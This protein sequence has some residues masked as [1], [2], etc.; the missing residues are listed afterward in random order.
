V[1]D[2]LM[3]TTSKAR[4]LETAVRGGDGASDL[5]FTPQEDDFRMRERRSQ[6]IQ[7]AT[8]QN[9]TFTEGNIVDEHLGQSDRRQHAGQHSSEQKHPGRVS[10]AVHGD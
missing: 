7:H 2:E 6:A 4:K 9:A 10:S 1:G 3:H 5:G 8:L